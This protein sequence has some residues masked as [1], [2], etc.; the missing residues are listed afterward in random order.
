MDERSVGWQRKCQI[1]AVRH[2]LCPWE[3]EENSQPFSR[4]QIWHKVLGCC[5]GH[6]WATPSVCAPHIPEQG[7]QPGACTCYTQTGMNTR[8]MSVW[9]KG[10]TSSQKDQ[11][12]AKQ[13]IHTS[14]T[15]HASTIG[16]IPVKD[17]TT[18]QS[19]E[20]GNP[21]VCFDLCSSP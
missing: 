9:K 7:P 15:H 20:M 16:H 21:K 2:K 19:W 6:S 17:P 3:E 4:G 11:W 12:Q 10:L 8:K 1:S 13:S 14:V 5:S 18:M